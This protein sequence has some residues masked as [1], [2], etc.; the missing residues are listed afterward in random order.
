[1]DLAERREL[2]SNTLWQIGGMRLVEDAGPEI[3][4]GTGRAAKA[5]QDD[6]TEAKAREALLQLDPLWD[7]LFPAEQA[8]IVQLLVE[9]VDVRTHGVEVR[10]R[11]N[12]F[13][14]LVREVAG[15]Q[16]AAA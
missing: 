7:E 13:A 15:N 16:R 10:L 1:M 9:R 2:G 6:V 3:I 8:R 12:G 11:P 4:I 5:E 14:G